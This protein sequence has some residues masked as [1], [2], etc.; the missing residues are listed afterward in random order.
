MDFSKYNIPKHT[1]GAIE[2][3]VDHGLF[4]G[5]FLEAVLTNDLFGAVGRADSENIRALKDIVMFVYN[6]VPSSAW[7]SK[8]QMQAYAKQMMYKE[9][10]KESA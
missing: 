3:W 1:Q 8:E 2:R 6:E 9:L 5:G 7:G 4:P 10:D